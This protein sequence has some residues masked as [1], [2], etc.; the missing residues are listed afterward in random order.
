MESPVAETT[1]T[2]RVDGELKE[3]FAQAAKK[4]DRTA[5]QLLRTL[6]REAVD[7][8]RK[9]ARDHDAWFRAEVEK[10]LREADDPNTRW[11][12]HERVAANLR[13]R[14]DKYLKRAR[15]TA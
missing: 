8:Q 11:I 5:A 12:P 3:A 4:E 13:R 14:R 10:A 6:M 9:E 2:F 1:F 7:G 15:K